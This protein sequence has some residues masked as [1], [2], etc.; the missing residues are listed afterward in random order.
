MKL[1]LD[2]RLTE[3]GYNSLTKF[4]DDSGIALRT[5]Q[6]IRKRGH[7]SPRII[8]QIASFLKIDSDSLYAFD[9]DTD[10]VEESGSLPEDADILRMV[11]ESRRVEE[12][13]DMTS[14]TK[15]GATA[16]QL[17]PSSVS[18]IFRNAELAHRKEEYMRALE[19]FCY[20]LFQASADDEAAVVASLDCFLDCC[21]KTG[22][23]KAVDRFHGLC[24]ELYQNWRIFA[25]LSNFY[26]LI[27]DTAAMNECL[28]EAEWAKKA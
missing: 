23:R 21:R 13:G 15:L 1:I 27:G 26:S 25:K 5:L 19:L 28:K 4:S 20:G 3:N 12:A 8:G 7:G 22:N 2:Q 6:D 24:P 9:G 14:A 10:T 17:E 18:A 11:K 16:Y